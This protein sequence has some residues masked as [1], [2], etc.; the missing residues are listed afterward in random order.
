[1]SSEVKTQLHYWHVQ[2]VNTRKGTLIRANGIVS[3]HAILRETNEINTSIIRQ[4]EIDTESDEAI[5]R[6]LNTV[7][8]CPLAYM[9]YEKQDCW[10]QLI[11][12][13]DWVK[14]KYKGKRIEPSIDPGKILL[15]LSNHDK[16]YFHSLFYKGQEKLP[17]IEYKAYPHIGTFHDSFLIFAEGMHFRYF[18]HYRNIE[19]YVE[20]TDGKPWF[21]EN[22]GD[23][24]L[25]ARTLLGTI[26][27]EPGERKEV[28]RENAEKKEISLDEGELYPPGIVES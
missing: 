11:P 27:L 15:V 19:F 7:Y 25:Y 17:P 26:K 8:Y 2:M 9:D 28:K 4:I 13:Y 12:K 22:I 5:I 21:L 6:T 3:G 20:V 18:P 16:Y 10:P 1:M 23:S 24:L 14:S